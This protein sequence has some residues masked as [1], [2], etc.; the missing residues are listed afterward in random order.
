MASSRKTVRRKP[1]LTRSE[2]KDAQDSGPVG[3]YVGAQIRLTHVAAIDA[4]EVLFAPFK[5]SPVRFALL[6]HANEFP[7]TT[8]ASIAEMLDV[9]RTTLVPMIAALEKQGLLRRQRLAEDR[10]ASE[11]WI[12][13]KGLTLLNKLKPIAQAHDR[14]L[15]K[16]LSAKEIDQLLAT[17][18]KIR[19][20]LEV[21]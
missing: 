12:T 16:G 7:G 5:S 14:T 11:V 17:L 8:Q 21:R 19:G 6:D 9:D 13:P 10:R 3:R 2:I 1:S 20:N 15:R 4:L 18:R